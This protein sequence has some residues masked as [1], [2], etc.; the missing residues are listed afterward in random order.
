[1]P[2]ATCKSTSGEFGVLPSTED[3]FIKVI[4]PID[5]TPASEAGI[6]P[7]DLIVKID[8]QLTKGLSMM[9]AGEMRGKAGSK[10]FY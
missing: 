6:Q 7:G 4:S 2:S 3:G 8:G 10:F 1:M 9:E 5:D